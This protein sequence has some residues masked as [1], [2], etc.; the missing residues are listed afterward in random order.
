MWCP[1]YKNKIN[2][3]VL[4]FV[5]IF[6]LNFISVFDNTIAYADENAKAKINN[7]VI[8]ED[9]FEKYMKENVE[10]Y[11]DNKRSTGYLKIDDNINL[12]YEKY[13]V[14]NSKGSIVISHGFGENLEKYK[15][16]IYYFLK[17]GYSVF[18]IEH[19]GHGRSG[20]LGVVD[21]SQI[22][23][24]DFNLYISDLKTFID[25][26][27]KKDIGSEKMF[28]YGHSMGGAI[29]AKFLEDYPQYF[30]AAILNAPM[31]EINTGSFPPFIAKSIAWL[32]TV[33][34]FGNKYAPTQ[35][36][37][38]NKYDLENSGTS[39]EP[40]YKYYYNIQSSNKELQRGG[41]S[42]NWLKESFDVTQEITK[43][44]NVSKVEIPTLI[45]QAEKD[46]HVKPKGQSDFAQYAKNCKLVCMTGSKHEIYREKDSILKAYLNRVFDFYNSNL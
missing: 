21:K 23:I 37:Y 25:E 40:R 27:V 32:G 17:N 44:E 22:N 2:Y 3:K 36:P 35:K 28:L 20:S 9:D 12:Y 10:P 15:E 38:T 16:M 18:G 5:L 13:K 43:K 42:L 34:P 39:S 29:G 11:L 8:L 45:F 6:S 1:N 41:S 24:K 26:V 14:E 46:D 4:L 30:D 33:L 7:L 19:R 31:L